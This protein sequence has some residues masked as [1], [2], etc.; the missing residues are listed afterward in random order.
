MDH[1]RRVYL[2]DPQSIPPET[3]A[4]AFAKTSRSPEP[5]D[6]IAAELSAE[7]SSEFHEKWVVG[8]GH[9]SVAEHAVLHIAVEN[10]SRLAVEVLE[11][12]RLASYTEKSTRYQ[13]WGESDYYIPREITST[14]LEAEYRSTLRLLHHTYETALDR[15]RAVVEKKNPKLEHESDAAYERR[16]R[17]IYVDVCRYLLPA[18]SLAN[19]GVTINARALEHALV[20]LLSSPLNEAREIGAAIKSAALQQTPTLIKYAEENAFLQETTNYLTRAAGQLRVDES[21][22]ADWLELS[23][24]DPEAET[25]LLTALLYRYARGNGYAQIFTHVSGLSADERKDLFAKILAKRGKFD[26]LPRE[27][28]HCTYTADLLVDQGAYFEI[29]RHRMM[30]QSPQ[31]F[32]PLYGYALPRLITE[33]GMEAAYHQALRTA[34]DTYWRIASQLSPDVAAYILPNGYNR[35]LLMTFN[36]RA[37][38]HFISLRSAPNAHFAVRRAAQRLAD[39]IRKVHPTLGAWLRPAGGETWQTIE[40]DHFTST[41]ID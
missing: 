9:A 41:R 36:F 18:A 23:A 33:S 14:P 15:V 10:I 21:R 4:V 29:K 11:S 5:F 1:E 19:V 13:K 27:M 22:Q 2:L 8:Y 24:D 40:S 28:E 34:A 6:V 35:R 37:A 12:N 38:D 31:P 32:S 3:I 30:T 25:R 17:T 20:K 39:E 16:L 26:P 7:K